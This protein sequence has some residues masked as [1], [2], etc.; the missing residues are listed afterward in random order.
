MHV[1]FKMYIG[2]LKCPLQ[3]HFKIKDKNITNGNIQAP[4][5]YIYN[6]RMN[7]KSE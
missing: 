3:L 6:V 4:Q 7:L 1:S 5:A 2:C